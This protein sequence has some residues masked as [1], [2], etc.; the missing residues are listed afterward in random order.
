MTR[1]KTDSVNILQDEIRRQ[2]GSAGTSRFARALPTFQ[3]EHRVPE[4]FLKLLT[5]LDQAEHHRNTVFKAH[6][7]G[8]P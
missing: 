1:I 2:F 4:R 6:G 7:G 8:K 5:E 3:V